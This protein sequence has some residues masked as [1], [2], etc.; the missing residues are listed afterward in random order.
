MVAVNDSTDTPDALLGKAAAFRRLAH[1]I[2]D[3]P[4]RQDLLRMASEYETRA[5]SN[6]GSRRAALS[7][8]QISGLAG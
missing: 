8:R 1:E 5:A 6:Y 3:G 7:G 4:F 2:L